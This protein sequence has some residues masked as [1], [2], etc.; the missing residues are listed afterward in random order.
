MYSVKT[1][2]KYG[3]STMN[4]IFFSFGKL[5]LIA[6]IAAQWQVAEMECEG[7]KITKFKIV[8]RESIIRYK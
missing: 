3:N 5:C 2:P 8:F 4:L 7:V 1:V 6:R